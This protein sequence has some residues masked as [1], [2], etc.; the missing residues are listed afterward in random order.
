MRKRSHQIILRLNDYEL[1]LLKTRMAEEDMNCSKLLRH[2][3]TDVSLK[4]YDTE[5][6]KAMLAQMS[7]IGSNVNQI[8]RVANSAKEVEKEQIAQA[9]LQVNQLWRMVKEMT[10]VWR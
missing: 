1:T 5:T 10:A 4:T 3:I 9:C 2:L 6:L 8:A 7:K